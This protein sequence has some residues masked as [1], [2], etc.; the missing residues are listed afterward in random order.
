M[1]REIVLE[2]IVCRKEIQMVRLKLGDT[3]ALGIEN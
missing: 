2:N 3:L 1:M